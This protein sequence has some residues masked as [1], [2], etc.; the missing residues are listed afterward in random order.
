VAKEKTCCQIG[1]YLPVVKPWYG[2]GLLK[3]CVKTKKMRA[4]FKELE[5]GNPEKQKTVLN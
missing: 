1:R 2:S 4:F 5:L 3:F